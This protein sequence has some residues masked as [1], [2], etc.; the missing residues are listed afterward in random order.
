MPWQFLVRVS[1]VAA[2]VTIKQKNKPTNTQTN[3]QTNKQNKQSG[4]V[5]NKKPGKKCLKD[6]GM[7][8]PSQQIIEGVQK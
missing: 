7:R 2:L 1:G 5:P 8:P 4:T 6:N 3:K